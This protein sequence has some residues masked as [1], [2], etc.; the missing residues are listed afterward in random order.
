MIQSISAIVWDVNPEI[1]RI[2]SLAVR[3]YGLAWVLSFVLGIYLTKRLFKYDKVNPELVDSAFMYVFIGTVIGARLGHTLFYGWEYY[4]QHPLDILKIW[5]GGLASHGAAI[6]IIASI[7][8]YSKYVLK[9]HMLWML[10]RTVIVV[11]LAGGLIRLGN[12]M[13]SEIVGSPTDLPWGF[14]FTALGDGISRHPSQIY[15]ALFYFALFILFWQLFFKTE[16][17]LSQ[18]K[19][20][21]LFMILLFGFR[22]MVEFFKENQE[23]FENG[24]ALNMGQILSIPMVLAG[25]YFYFFP[26]L[27]KSIKIKK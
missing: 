8:L 23:A 1:F 10:D 27:S 12:L 3:W 2:G 4:S 5:E 17:R 16:I 24:M 15:E 21:G 14:V 6:G 20:F 26:T 25:I 9:K 22:I 7:W 19:I 11:A 18:G 13:N